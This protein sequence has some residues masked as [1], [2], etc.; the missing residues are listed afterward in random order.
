MAYNGTGEQQAEYTEEYQTDYVEPSAEY[1]ELIGLGLDENVAKELDE[2]FQTGE[3]F[4]FLCGILFVKY[5]FLANMNLHSRLL[6]AVAC[7]SV[8]IKDVNI[9]FFPNPDI[10]C[11]NPVKIR[12]SDFIRAA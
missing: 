4:H 7:L 6:Y 2:F 11:D 1:Q 12:I 9:E 10:E 3:H 8:C 5:W